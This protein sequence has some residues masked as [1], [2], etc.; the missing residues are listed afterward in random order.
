[1]RRFAAA[2]L[3]ASLP[4]L[5]AGPP[6]IW[7]T[8]FDNDVVFHTDRWYTSGVRITRSQALAGDSPLA[9]ARSDATG[10]QRLDIGIVH[11]IYTPETDLGAFGATVDRPYAGRLLV[12]ALRQVRGPGS[13]DTLGVEAGVTG[14]AALARQ[15]Q[16]IVHRFIPGPRTDWSKQVANRA[17]LQLVAALS[18]QVAPRRGPG[19]IILHGGGVLGSVTT[20]AHAGLEWRSRAGAPANPLLR[21]AATPPL[22][23]DGSRNLAFFA[24]VSFR[25]VL[26]NLLLD[27]HQ[28]DP[29]ED[30]ARERR[31]H[32]FAF[33]LAWP[34][35]WGAVTFGVAEDSPEFVGQRSRQHF[36]T[37]T[38]AIAFD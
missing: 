31:V 25:A 13:L 2:A 22:A 26:R 37:L 18:R 33:G 23:D 4:A 5:G 11:E 32:R 36:G 1:V 19:A 17:D 38:V 8:Q 14:P 15:T 29:R 27:L 21:L 30:P 35:S 24:G 7:H 20:F 10:V 16:D 3:A 12:S 6:V 28:G 9:A 34:A